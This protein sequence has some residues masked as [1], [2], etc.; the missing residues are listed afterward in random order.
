VNSIWNYK[1]SNNFNKLWFY[2]CKRVL[3][4]RPVENS[5]DLDFKN[6]SES[7]CNYKETFLNL[8][9]QSIKLENGK[10]FRAYTIGPIEINA[11][12]TYNSILCSGEKNIQEK[13]SNNFLNINM[14]NSS[15]FK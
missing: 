15:K 14:N 5:V 12:S 7:K 2:W 1:L 10:L 3:P 9:R 11:I 13:N 6:V 8:L 4:L